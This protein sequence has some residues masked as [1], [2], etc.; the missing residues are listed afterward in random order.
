M[1]VYVVTKAKPLESEMY[2]GV[3]KSVKD[4]EKIMRANFPYMRKVG[5]EYISEMNI[6]NPKAYLLFVHE[7]EI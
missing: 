4:A 5:N 2:V 7:E 1:K 3:A 6:S